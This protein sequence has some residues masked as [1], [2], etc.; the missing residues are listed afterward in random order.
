MTV[1]LTTRFSISSAY[2]PL[3][4]LCLNYD[5]SVTFGLWLIIVNNNNSNTNKKI[6]MKGK[7]K[8]EEEENIA[9][10][11]MGKVKKEEVLR[12]TKVFS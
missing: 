9:L 7:E 2:L 11:Q 3:L 10:L 6:K 8:E 5:R 4:G 12:R 1:P